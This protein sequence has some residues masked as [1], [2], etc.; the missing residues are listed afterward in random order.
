MMIPV[1]E[2][3][4]PH[5][6]INMFPYRPFFFFA[7]APFPP[8]LF[9]WIFCHA[10]L[11]YFF[12]VGTHPRRDPLTQKFSSFS[13]KLVSVR[14]DGPQDSVS[15]D[16][17]FRTSPAWMETVCNAQFFR[18]PISTCLLRFLAASQSWN[19]LLPAPHSLS[20]SA[21]QLLFLFSFFFCPR[22]PPK[23]STKL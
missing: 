23:F 8:S 4:S 9:S 10:V 5:V 2:S 18:F 19:F 12:T 11:A 15:V 3:V 6:L 16:S 22:S 20:R 1:W 21:Y 13:L 7:W 14:V 17:Y